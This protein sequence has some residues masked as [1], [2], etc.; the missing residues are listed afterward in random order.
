MKIADFSNQQSFLYLMWP[1]KSTFCKGIKKR[2]MP[3]LLR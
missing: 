3:P 1:N 2:A